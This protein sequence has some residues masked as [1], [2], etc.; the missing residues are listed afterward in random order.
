MHKEF[1]RIQV[2][3]KIVER[4]NLA[5]SYCYYFEGGDQSYKDKP[6]VIGRSTAGELAQF[7]RQ[8]AIDLGLDDVWVAF[9]GGEPMMIKPALFDEICSTLGKALDGVCRLTLD[10]QTN[11]YH[12]TE[13]WLRLFDKHGVNVSVSIDGVGSTHDRFRKNHRGGGSYLKIK[14]NYIKMRDHLQAKGKGSPSVISVLSAK[15]N[16]RDQISGLYEEL[17]IRRFNFL[18]P[19][20]NHDDGIP[21]GFTASDYGR[22]L[23]EIFDEWA[24]R[25]DIYVREIENVIIRFQLATQKES[26]RVQENSVRTWKCVENQII[27]V[28]SDGELQ[29]DDTF[30]PASDW[31]NSLTKRQLSDCS[32]KDYLGLSVFAEIDDLYS[33]R[34]EK[35]SSCVWGNICNGGDLENRYSKENGFDN[36]SVYCD[37]LRMF[38]RK[39]ARYLR[40]NGYPASL[41]RDR[42]TPTNDSHQHSYAR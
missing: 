21:D 19:D 2:I 27:V 23:C 1:R 7:L 13:E 32:L 40:T 4:C 28:R 20:C 3:L 15:N 5:C 41:M 42:L 37:G 16:Y 29:I 18:L 36:P 8:G 26:S 25:T 11:G 33:R 14:Q 30:I 31:R 39:I 35:C 24:E 9:H 34:P 12:I 38:Y 6:A 17:G 10:L 22:I